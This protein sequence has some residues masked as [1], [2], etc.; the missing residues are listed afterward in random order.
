[1]R[2]GY[3]FNTGDSIPRGAAH[4]VVNGTS[5]NRV[6]GPL[7]AIGPAIRVRNPTA[8][9]LVMATFISQGTKKNGVRQRMT[10]IRNSWSA[11]ER[12]C[13][14]DLGQQQFQELLSLIFGE[15]PEELLLTV[16]ATAREDLTRLAG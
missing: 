7:F 3:V 11:A 16:G 13:R 12:C 5:A 6:F 15:P 9:E 2:V 8:K 4:F 1:V 14:A 10:A